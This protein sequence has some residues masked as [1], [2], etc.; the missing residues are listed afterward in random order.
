MFLRGRRVRH[1]KSGGVYVI[2]SDLTAKLRLE[3]SDEPAYA[4][5]SVDAGEHPTWV[6]S[7]KEMEDG[8]FEL[9]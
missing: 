2:V 3:S 6:R 7:A 9:V 4:Y 1:K 8:R 5:T